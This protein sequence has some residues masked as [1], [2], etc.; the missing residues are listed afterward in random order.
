[1]GQGFPSC[2]TTSALAPQEHT[3]VLTLGA[4]QLTLVGALSSETAWSIFF[5]FTVQLS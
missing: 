3:P 4:S 2:G 1:M 5:K